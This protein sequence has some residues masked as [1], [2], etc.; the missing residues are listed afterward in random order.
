M[1]HT[2]CENREAALATTPGD[3]MQCA[4]GITVRRDSDG[5]KY[6]FSPNFAAWVYPREHVCRAPKPKRVTVS[7]NPVTLFE[8]EGAD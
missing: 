6:E 8:R 3:I 4:C 5:Q 7:T 1:R 2:L